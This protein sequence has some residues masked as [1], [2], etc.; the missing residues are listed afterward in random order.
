MAREIVLWCDVDMRDDQR[1]PGSTRT[2][3]LGHGPRE[4]DL[5]DQHAKQYL[6]PLADILD[7]LGSRAERPQTLR[8]RA[9]AR[10]VQG[11]SKL[12]NLLTTQ[13][14]GKLPDD[15]DDGRGFQCLFCTLDYTNSGSLRV[16]I[17]KLHGFTDAGFPEIFGRACPLC[18]QSGYGALSVHALNTHNQPNVSA[19]FVAAREAGDPHGIVAERVALAQN[20]R[21]PE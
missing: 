1:V 6:E 7:E 20:V 14:R 10:K 12:D 8:P 21:L 13:R 3:D 2:L 19:L 11:L 16:H 18:G 17:R 4:I 15:D 5:C 9:D